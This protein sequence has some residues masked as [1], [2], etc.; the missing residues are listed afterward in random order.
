MYF[1]PKAVSAAA[2][3]AGVVNF[4]IDEAPATVYV[5]ICP[6]YSDSTFALTVN[7]LTAMLD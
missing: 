2:A 6:V 4:H 7:D 3:G 1:H 5:V